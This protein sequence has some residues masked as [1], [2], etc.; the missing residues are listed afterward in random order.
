MT[1]II[2]K[3][4]CEGQNKL[5]CIEGIEIDLLNG[6]KALIYPK[7]SEEII[8][9]YDK[10]GL[11]KAEEM[12]EIEA[13]KVKDTFSETSILLSLDSPAAKWVRQ[14]ASYDYGHRCLP[15]L[16]AAMEI[17]HQ[18]K[19]IDALAE[20]IEGADLLR[21]FTSNVWSCSR[22]GAYHCWYAND[23]GGYARN[24]YLS[25]SCLVVPL[26]LLDVPQS[27]I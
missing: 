24:Y 1:K 15:S 27:A 12:S 23:I 22:Y 8:L 4:G 10:R 18:K 19:E 2:Y 25:Y 21:D 13:L 16:L 20:T 11:W 26:V 9:P 17:Q 3:E 7:Y 6:Q 5:S 14:F